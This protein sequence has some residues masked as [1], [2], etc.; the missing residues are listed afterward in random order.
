MTAYEQAVRAVQFLGVDAIEKA[1]SGHPGAVMG[2]AGIGVELFTRHLRYNPADPAWPNRDRFVLSCG[3]ASMLQYALLHLA[4]YDLGLEDLKQFRQWGARTAGHPEVG[5]A[6]GVETT[7]GPLGQ[8]IAN[9]V[10]MALAGKM[11]AA[12]VNRP[13]SELFDYRVFVIAS[14]GDLMEGISAEASAIAGHL[15]LDN[16]VVLYDDNEITIDG[17]TS[18][19]SREDTVKRFEAQGWYAQAVDG[20]D[21]VALAAA[22]E[23]AVAEPTRPSLIAARTVIGRGAPTKA[24]TSACHGAPLG[25][26]EAEAAKR[27]A[28]WP[29]EPAFFVPEEAYVPFKEQVARN[30]PAYDAWQQRVQALS[31]EQAD[32]LR[33]LLSREVPADLRKVLFGC[34]DAKKA[35]ATRSLA[36]KVQQKAAAAV[37][38][39][40]GG[41]ADLAC[42]VKSLI[43]DSTDVGPGQFSGRNLHFGVREHAMAAIS[44]GLALSGFFIPY[45]STFLIFSDYMRPAMR[46]AALM[47][48]QS[49]FIFSHDSVFVGEDGPTHQPIEQLAT[50]RLVPNLHIFRPADALETEAAW[51]YALERRKGPTAIVTTRQNVPPIER[52]ADFTQAEVMAGAYV[53]VDEPGAQLALIATGS[54]LHVAAAARKLLQD[55]G[56]ASRLV[57]MPCVNAFLALSAEQQGKLLPAGLRRVSLEASH[58]LPWRAIVG[59]DG[60]AIGLE[61][62]GTSAPWERIRD[63][64]GLTGPAVAERIL[65]WLGR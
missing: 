3:H 13:G 35:D 62:F 36:N 53:V 27:A 39:L 52:R 65:K 38:A 14:D 64:F 8:G 22:I 41:S 9:A 15:G 2:L 33:R 4:G 12:R 5:H 1:N 47:R 42:S 10:G 37:P 17:A 45:S 23:R 34:L 50:L 43:N 60:L 7:T 49:L 48:Q 18:L 54:E 19:S 63:E 56:I 51:A 58:P 32:A 31:A 29:L 16:L 11:A 25:K 20:H 40:V 59:L 21:A 55:K 26:S 44:N 30:K 46:M 28:G 57:S 24:G 6:P 61:D